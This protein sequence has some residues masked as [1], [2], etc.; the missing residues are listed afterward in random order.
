M[1]SNA[2][3]LPELPDPGPPAPALPLAGRRRERPW[4]RTRSAAFL[5]T[6]LIVAVVLGGV[7]LGFG[8][9]G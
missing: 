4:Y 1:Q 7:M 5:T 3:P 2:M 9:P 8:A 6:L